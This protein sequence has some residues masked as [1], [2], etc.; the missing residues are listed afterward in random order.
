MLTI[1]TVFIMMTE[2]IGKWN[3][4]MK[5]QYYCKY[6]VIFGTAVFEYIVAACVVM[7]FSHDIKSILALSVIW[8]VGA[9]GIFILHESIIMD[10]VAKSMDNISAAIEAYKI[11]RDEE[12]LINAWEYRKK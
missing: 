7:I 4:P 8:I 10:Y 9:G 11:V 6:C 2:H 12:F 5:K 3:D 1:L